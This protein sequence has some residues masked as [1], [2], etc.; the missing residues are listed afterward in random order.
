MQNLWF[1]YSW[2]Y[3][4]CDENLKGVESGDQRSRYVAFACLQHVLVSWE[5]P[6][7]D[8]KFGSLCAKFTTEHQNCAVLLHLWSILCK[9]FCFSDWFDCVIMDV[10]Q[11][12]TMP[13]IPRAHRYNSW[14]RRE[15]RQRYRSCPSPFPYEVCCIKI[16]YSCSK[17]L[18]IWV[19]N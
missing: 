18:T 13:P 5:I 10:Y 19:I 7:F 12:I 17:F 2:I 9:S 4:N 15:R 8:A 6:V 11:S 16:W 3:S 14:E 1:I